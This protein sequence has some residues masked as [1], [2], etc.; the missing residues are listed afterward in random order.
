MLNLDLSLAGEH[1]LAQ[2]NALEEFRLD[3][4]ENARIFKEKTKRWH[5]RLIKPKE[6]HEGD[7]F[8]LYNSRLRLFPRKVKSR[9]TGPYVV[10]HV[11]PY[12][13]IEIQNQDEMESFKVNWHRLNRILLEDLLSNIRASKSVEDSQLS[14]ADDYNSELLLTL[15]LVRF[16]TF[17]YSRIDKN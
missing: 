6:F 3:A 4:Y 1:K 7:K 13:A 8:L 5:D 9:W 12:G 10:K 2:I 16:F 15:L 17:V 14:Q 11:S